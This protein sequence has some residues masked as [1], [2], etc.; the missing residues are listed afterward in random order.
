MSLALE[1]DGVLSRAQAR[2]CGL[3]RWAVAHQVAA[4][5]WQT[6]GDQS[7]AVHRLPLGRR[8]RSRVAVWEAGDRAALDGA[9]ALAWHG[10]A[11]FDD[12]VHVVVPWPHRTVDWPGAVVHPSRLWH[13]DDIEVRD[14]L[15]VTK[16]AVSAIRAAMWARSDR[17]AATVMAMSVQQKICDATDLML[18]ARRLNR[19]KR[20][21]LLLVIARDIAEGAEALSEL[22][23]A[24]WC[25]RRRLPTPSRQVLRR[26]FNAR[27]FLDV[28]WDDWNVAV[29]IEGAHHDAPEHA[30]DDA[31]RQ[32]AVTIDHVHFLRIPV[33]GLRTQPNVFMDQVT[34]MLRAAGWSPAA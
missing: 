25:R 18:E 13:P 22:D 34:A 7:I 30:V 6:F 24:V 11:G 8:A 26:G 3:D 14:G 4:G 10:L 31:L 33:L 1:Q 20:R 16:P 32:N 21:P 29:E 27:A 17:A 19:H 28:L 15:R 5:R 12:G 9:S 2:A 23:F